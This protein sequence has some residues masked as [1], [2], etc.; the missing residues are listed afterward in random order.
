VNHLPVNFIIH[1]TPFYF[2]NNSD[3]TTTTTTSV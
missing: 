3:K 1:W 2:S